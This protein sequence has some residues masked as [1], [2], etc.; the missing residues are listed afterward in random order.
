V[1]A[2]MLHVKPR[3]SSVERRRLGVHARA[4]S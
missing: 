3:V 4:R 2:V 1:Q